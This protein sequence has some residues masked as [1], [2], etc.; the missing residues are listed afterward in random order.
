VWGVAQRLLRLAPL[1]TG[2]AGIATAPGGMALLSRG[3]TAV[4]MI[5]G[6]R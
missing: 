3:L 4:S 5:A 1:T 6:Q 2:P